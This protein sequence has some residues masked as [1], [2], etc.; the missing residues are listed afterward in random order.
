[1]EIIGVNNITNT[2]AVNNK[3]LSIDD[4]LKIMAAEIKNQNVSGDESGGGRSKNLF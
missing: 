1:M 3:S 4:F 2:N